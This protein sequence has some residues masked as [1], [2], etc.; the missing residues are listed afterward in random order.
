MSDFDKRVEQFKRTELIRLLEQ[1]TDK[2][3]EFFHRVFPGNIPEDKLKGAADLC[4]R[5]IKKNIRG[6][7]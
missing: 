3:Q 1:C 2:Q 6:R 7:G 4:E 5:T